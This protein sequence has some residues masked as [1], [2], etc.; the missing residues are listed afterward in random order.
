MRQRTVRIM[1][2]VKQGQGQQRYYPAVLAA[3]GTV[4][5]FYAQIAGKA[6]CREDGVYYLRYTD[7]GKK[8]HYQYVGTDPK[9]A[10]TMQLQR[11]HVIAGEK[12]GSKP[13]SRPALREDWIRHRYRTSSKPRS[14]L[15]R[16]CSIR[17][18]LIGVAP[19]ERPPTHPS[20]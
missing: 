20:I 16:L 17:C 3:N 6:E 2:R 5:P 14:R 12:I 8:R 1:L 18:Y 15:I 19:A 9:L 4:K 13:W 7:S 11:H 10:R